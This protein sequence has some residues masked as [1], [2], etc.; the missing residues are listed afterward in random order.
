MYQ[1]L[2]KTYSETI[3][4]T[5]LVERAI[6]RSQYNI[7]IESVLKQIFLFQQ[8]PMSNMWY[9]PMILEMYICLPFLSCIVHKF[10]ANIFKL[11]FIINLAGVFLAVVAGYYIGCWD[12]N[13]IYATT[14]DVTLEMDSFAKRAEIMNG[15][16]M[17]QLP[18][19]LQIH[20]QEAR[21]VR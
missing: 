5:D 7:T 13:M 8:P 1:K 17:K 21:L 19:V 14:Y 11:A 6:E 15:E 9:F 20:Y 12:G 18:T 16:Y 10:N 2:L 4:T 3:Q